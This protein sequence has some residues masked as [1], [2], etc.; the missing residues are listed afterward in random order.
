MNNSAKI[1]TM[2]CFW[3]TAFLFISCGHSD[4]KQTAS[5][6]DAAFQK[7]RQKHSTKTTDGTDLQQVFNSPGLTHWQSRMKKDY[8]HFSA[9]NFHQTKQNKLPAQKTRHFSAEKWQ[10]FQSYFIKGPQGKLAIDLY[11]YSHLPSAS[12]NH[13]EAGSPDNEV[14]LVHLSNKTKTRLL[15]AGPGTDFQ[16]AEWLNDSIIIVMG[17]SDANAQN[18]MKPMFWK[19]NI[20]SKTV[21]EYLYKDTLAA[22]PK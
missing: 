3:S 16:Q 10:I 12:G 20:Q 19:I 15:F 9:D 17:E 11:S 5:E 8:P 6:T 14:N 2:L 21:T 4:K 22:N 13:L 18:K 1:M 7:L